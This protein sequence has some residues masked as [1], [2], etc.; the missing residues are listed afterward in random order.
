[1]LYSTAFG[2]VQGCEGTVGV[3]WRLEE[4]FGE[5]A[6]TLAFFSHAATCGDPIQHRIKMDG[7]VSILLH[8]QAQELTVWFRHEAKTRQMAPAD[9]RRVES[10][11]G[12]FDEHN[13]ER[14]RC[15]Q[16]LA[17]GYPIASGVIEAA[18]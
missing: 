3:S 17:A 13:W 4:F 14:M 8:G 18:F 7:Y 2:F 11:C 1:M 15:D 5:S 10:I 12:Y 6:Q 9:A 16:Y